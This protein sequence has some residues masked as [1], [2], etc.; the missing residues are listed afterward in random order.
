MVLNLKWFKP[1][2]LYHDSWILHFKLFN[3]FN[4]LL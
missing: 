2:L 3:F 1:H 4:F